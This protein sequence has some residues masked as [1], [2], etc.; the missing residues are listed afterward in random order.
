MTYAEVPGIERGDVY[1][2][3]IIV[4]LLVLGVAFIIRGINGGGGNG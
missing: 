3:A 1:V 4:A 2:A